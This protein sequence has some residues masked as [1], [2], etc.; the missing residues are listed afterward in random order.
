MAISPQGGI[1]ASGSDDQ[2]L[3]LWQ[4]KTGQ[5]WEFWLKTLPGLMA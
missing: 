1:F 2:T 5:R 4:L 3:R